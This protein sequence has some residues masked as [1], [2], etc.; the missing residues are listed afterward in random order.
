[1]TNISIHHMHITPLRFP[2]YLGPALYCACVCYQTVTSPVML[3]VAL[4]L[5]TKD[6]LPATL[7]WT[8]LGGGAVTALLGMA[9]VWCYMVPKSR[10]TFYPVRY[11]SNVQSIPC[12]Q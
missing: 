7:L 9:L 5:D 6:R 12:S 3:L 4:H 2:G 8:L 11:F 10:C 1:M